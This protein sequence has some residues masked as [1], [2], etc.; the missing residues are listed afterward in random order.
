[1]RFQQKDKSLIEIA[2]E[3]PKDYFIK[4]FYGAGKTYSLTCRYRNIMIQKW[5][6]NLNNPFVEWYYYILCHPGETRTK[7][8]IDQY[9]HWKGLQNAVHDIC[10]KCHT[11]QFLKCGTRHYGKLPAKQVE[12]QLWYT[13]CIDLTG[14]YGMTPNKGGQSR[15]SC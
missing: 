6:Q 13:L 2:K 3:K 7:L 14:K 1:M 15:P 10:S 5:I 11:C 9:F 4:Q 8:S 12:I